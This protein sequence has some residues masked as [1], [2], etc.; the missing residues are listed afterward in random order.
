[1]VI[2][3]QNHNTILHYIANNSPS[4]YLFIYETIKERFNKIKKELQ[5]CNNKNYFEFIMN[6]EDLR[7]GEEKSM[8][9]C[10]FLQIKRRLK[11][12]R[13]KLQKNSEL[14]IEMN[15][16][17]LRLNKIFN[18]DINNNELFLRFFDKLLFKDF[19]INDLGISSFD[20]F[21]E[22]TNFNEKFT[23]KNF[24]IDFVFPLKKDLWDNYEEKHNCK[25]F[26]ILKNFVIVVQTKIVKIIHISRC[27][28]ACKYINDPYILKYVI[29]HTCDGEDSLDEYENNCLHYLIESRDKMIENI[30]IFISKGDKNK[31]LFIKK[32]IFGI[33]PLMMITQYIKDNNFIRF[34]IDNVKITKSVD[35]YDST[36]LHYVSYSKNEKLYKYLIENFKFD[37][38]KKNIFGETPYNIMYFNKI[39]Y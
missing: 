37:N 33:S 18:F 30:K 2:I 22:N 24:I 31:S 36:F 34:I 35:I 13:E 17:D 15:E 5:Q 8:M 38:M 9:K 3:G 21:K 7:E 4:I 6:S 29:L 27:F 11:K 32:N 20:M 39:Y 28:M 23:F 14:K 16:I 12:R 1:M 10:L 26:K 19:D 25:N